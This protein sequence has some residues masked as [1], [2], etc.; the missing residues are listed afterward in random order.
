MAIAKGGFLHPFVK[1]VNGVEVESV[2]YEKSTG[3]RCLKWPIDA[4][5]LVATG[6]Y[7]FD[8]PTVEAE[9][10]AIVVDPIEEPVAHPDTPQSEPRRGPGRPRKVIQ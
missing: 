6:E 10:D 4:K 7:S 5:E 2:V 8:P 9:P 3:R 1:V